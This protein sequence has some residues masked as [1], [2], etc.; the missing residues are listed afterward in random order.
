MITNLIYSQ[1]DSIDQCT[2]G[3]SIVISSNKNE[4]IH[5]KLHKVINILG[6]ESKTQKN[7][8]LF[9]IYENGLVEKK[10][11]IDYFFV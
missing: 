4:H 1:L 3:S 11:I 9:F 10:I 2:Y 6:K 7:I 5:Q 8:P